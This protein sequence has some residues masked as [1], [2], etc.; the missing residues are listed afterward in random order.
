MWRIASKKSPTAEVLPRR[1]TA[2]KKSRD[3][4][5]VRDFID[6]NN[7]HQSNTSTRIWR[8]HGIETLSALP[9]L[10]GDG[11]CEVWYF[12]WW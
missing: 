12:L 3:N 10:Y 11:E 2:D 8:R 7:Y 6:V 5:S 1:L 9:I 4:V